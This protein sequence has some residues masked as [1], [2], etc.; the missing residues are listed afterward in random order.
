MKVSEVNKTASFIKG[1][2]FGG[3]QDNHL[4]CHLCF[5]QSEP[6]DQ[7]AAVYSLP[8]NNDGGHSSLTIHQEERYEM[9]STHRNKKAL[10][11]Q[12]RS[13]VWSRPVR[14]SLLF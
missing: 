2:L 1:N 11:L 10:F 12:D 6:L 7:I 9:A 13:P 14:V 3:C 4:M 8:C 5:T